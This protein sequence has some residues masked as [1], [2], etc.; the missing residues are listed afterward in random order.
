MR[1]YSYPQRTTVGIFVECL[2]NEFF[3]VEHSDD[4]HSFVAEDKIVKDILKSANAS[5]KYKLLLNECKEQTDSG[6]DGINLLWF[7]NRFPSFPIWLGVRKVEFQRDTFGTLH[8]RF[9]KT[10]CFQ[11]WEEVRDT[12]P[13]NDIRSAGCVFTWPQFGV[14]CIHQYYPSCIADTDG[15]WIIKKLPSFEDPFIIEPLNQLLKTVNWNYPG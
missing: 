4:S 9:T 7:V 2:L 6:S 3:N 5:D 13:E 1:G 12:L 8:K 11:A 15:L 14:C 10:P